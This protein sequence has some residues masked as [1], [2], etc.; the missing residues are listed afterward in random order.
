MANK[1][2]S[3]VLIWDLGN[4]LLK[5]DVLGFAYEIGLA[6]FI[7][8]PLIDW[9]NPQKIH[10]LAFELLNHIDAEKH[11]AYPLATARGKVLPAIM[12][13]WLAGKTSHEQI[14]AKIEECLKRG[15]FT[16]TRQQR[17]VTQ[18]LNVLLDPEKFVRC[19]KPIGEGLRLLKECAEQVDEHGNKRHKLYILS[20]W[21][22]NSFEHLLHANKALFAYFDVH[23]ITISGHIGALKPQPIIYQQFI[24]KYKLE[25]QNCILIDDQIENITEAQ[26]QGITG[27]LLNNENYEHLKTQL[28]NL[29]VL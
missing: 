25:P 6:D 1:I 28:K 9:Q 23:N 20:N 26:N 2:Q 4:T 13:H 10:E 11:E 19:M 18:T 21:D 15:Q 5:A 8:Y 12:C 3:K 14:S 22:A 24:E 16:S 27:L 17:L 7:L 29:R